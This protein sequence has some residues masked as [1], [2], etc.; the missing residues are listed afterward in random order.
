MASASAPVQTPVAHDQQVMDFL[1][2]LSNKGPVAIED[3]PER[4]RNA[5][6]LS[7]V[8]VKDYIEIG[9]RQYAVASPGDGVTVKTDHQTGVQ[10]VHRKLDCHISDEWT[11]TNLKAPKRKQLWELMEEEEISAQKPEGEDTRLPK[12]VRLHVRITAEGLAETV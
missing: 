7:K 1:K 9:Q 2:F 11:W 4:F 12:E 5:A 10:T 6:F 8:L 3:L